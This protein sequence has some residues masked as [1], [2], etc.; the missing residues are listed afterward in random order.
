ML[1]LSKYKLWFYKGEYMIFEAYHSTIKWDILM[2]TSNYQSLQVIEKEISFK[3]V[4]WFMLVPN[5]LILKQNLGLE[6]KNTADYT[7]LH[8]TPTKMFSD[9]CSI[10]I[11]DMFPR[12]FNTVRAS[13]SGLR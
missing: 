5:M 3:N 13:L 1:I 11:L 4:P 10:I 2:Q 12:F 7:N 9:F 6:K 8:S